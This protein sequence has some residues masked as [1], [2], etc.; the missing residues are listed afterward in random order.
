MQCFSFEPFKHR[1]EDQATVAA[2]RAEA[3]G[4]D[5]SIKSM[6]RRKADADGGALTSQLAAMA[7][8]GAAEAS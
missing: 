5:V 4:V 1:S 2:L 6:G 7:S 8:K 3:V